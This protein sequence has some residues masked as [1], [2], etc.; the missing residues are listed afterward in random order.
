MAA[1][2]W[3]TEAWIRTGRDLNDVDTDAVWH[4]YS[5]IVSRPLTLVVS[6]NT[7]R[8]SATLRCTLQPKLATPSALSCCSRLEPIPRVEL[9]C[10]VCPRRVSC[11]PLSL[12]ALSLI[13]EWPHRGPGACNHTTF[14]AAMIVEAL[15]HGSRLRLPGCEHAGPRGTRGHFEATSVPFHT[16]FQPTP[17]LPVTPT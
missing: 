3:V 9:G 17:S 14:S 15:S 7:L 8:S 4:C 12:T 11:Q 5:E 2:P 6:L 1:T 13:A 10:A 16:P